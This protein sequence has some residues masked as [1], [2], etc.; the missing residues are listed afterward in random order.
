MNSTSRPPVQGSP[1]ALARDTR[2]R[3]LRGVLMPRLPRYATRAEKF[4]AAVL[5]TYAPVLDRFGERLDAL[6]IAVDLVPRMRLDSATSYWSD[7]V[8]ADGA[9]P[10]GRLVPAGVDETGAPTRPRLIIFRRPVEV[11]S[12]DRLDTEQWLRFIIARLVA[13]YLNISPEMVDPGAA[14]DL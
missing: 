13:T 8:A 4:D 10:L 3:G 1:R 2:G 14:K 12:A 6:D 5:D 7:E 11:R 9:V